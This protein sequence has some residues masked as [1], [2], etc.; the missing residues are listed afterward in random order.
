MSGSDIAGPCFS[1][2]KKVHGELHRSAY[3]DHN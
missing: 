2:G 3:L 1:N